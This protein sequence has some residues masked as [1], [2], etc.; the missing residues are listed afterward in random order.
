MVILRALELSASKVSLSWLVFWWL[1][2]VPVLFILFI[3]FYFFSYVLLDLFV[4]S[5]FS[6]NIYFLCL[7]C[8]TCISFLLGVTCFA[9]FVS[10]YPFCLLSPLYNHHLHFK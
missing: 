10:Q 2:C 4:Y 7:F 8:L 1:T 9:A 6:G 5:V 3:L